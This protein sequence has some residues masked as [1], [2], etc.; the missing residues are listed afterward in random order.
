M[1]RF[2]SSRR[3][4]MT[5]PDACTEVDSFGRDMRD[6]EVGGPEYCLLV[7]AASIFSTVVVPWVDHYHPRR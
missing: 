5:K 1:Y 7:G 3:A 6:A 2:K 4:V